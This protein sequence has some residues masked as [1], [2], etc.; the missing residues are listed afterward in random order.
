M[1]CFWDGIMKSLTQSDFNFIKEKKTDNIDFIKMLK[2]RC[3]LTTNVLWQ[4]KPL[5]EQEITEH[6]KAIT[7]YDINEIS[8]GHLTSVCDSFL[9]LICEL[10]KVNIIH[11][12]MNIE[13]K[14][15]NKEQ[16][17]KTIHYSSNNGHF[18]C[19]R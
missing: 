7:E 1:T 2:K 5:R 18:V 4:G 3:Q 8:N 9:L 14:Y 13:I 16:S 6:I 12:Y 11:S 15:T 10:F 17:R 19:S